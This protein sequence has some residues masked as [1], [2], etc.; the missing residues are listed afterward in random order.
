MNECEKLEPVLGNIAWCE[1]WNRPC[2]EMLKTHHEAVGNM[3][4]RSSL[5]EYCN[6]FQRREL[7]RSLPK[8]FRSMTFETLDTSRSRSLKEVFNVCVAYA[9]DPTAKPWLTLYG[10]PGVG[11]THFGVAI[12]RESPIVGKLAIWTEILEAVKAEFVK[13]NGNGSYHFRFER[14]SSPDIMREIQKASL[15][16][17]DDIGSEY[18]SDWA[19]SQLSLLAD[20]RY[21]NELPTIWTT[22]RNV[23]GLKGRVGSRL[24]DWQIGKIVFVDAPDYRIVVD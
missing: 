7:L 19:D 12:L 21:R 15:L 9:K 11:K 8:G 2:D 10:Q 6:C 16:L 17:V 5:T 22:N 18:S 20:Y 23:M 13:A 24:R 3:N 4:L 14:S 1:G